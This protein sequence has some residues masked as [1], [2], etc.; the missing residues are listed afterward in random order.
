M[1]LLPPNAM[2]E[3]TLQGVQSTGNARAITKAATLTAVMMSVEIAGGWAFNSM[4]LLADGWHMSSH[5]LVLLFALSIAWYAER[6]QSRPERAARVLAV[7]LIAASVSAMIM[8]WIAASM[9]YESTERLHAPEAVQY[10]EALAIAV[11]GLITNIFSARWLHSAYHRE[12]AAVD[13]CHVPHER[14]ADEKG[15]DARRS[16]NLRAAYLRVA[17]DTAVTALAITALVVGMIWDVTWLDSV[18]GLIG[19]S[20]VAVWAIRL[21]R[22]SISAWIGR[23]K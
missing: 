8:L 4:A 15:A 18:T 6:N 5:V 22:S 1:S 10:S 11:A 17:T 19:A 13:H 12:G 16:P 9:A 21:L 3:R 7:E 2:H 20:V 23:R 14:H